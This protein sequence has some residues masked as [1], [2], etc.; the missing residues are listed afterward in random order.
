[1]ISVPLRHYVEFV[2]VATPDYLAAYGVPE[3]PDDLH[4]HQC[5]RARMPSGS[6]SPWE[7][8]RTGQELTIHVPGRLT[9]D[10]PN[11]MLEAARSGFGL[12]YLAHTYA[13]D[14]LAS[15]RLI[16]V[17]ADWMPMEYGLHL[18]YP[19]RRHVPAGLR[20]LVNLINERRTDSRMGAPPQNM[21]HAFTIGSD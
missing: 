9:L 5:I 14:D 6:P 16:Q 8:S 18:Y 15:G 1:M 17:L 3:S 19:G 21:T 11:L 13:L 10:E 4:S 20:A 2:V 12:G 7:F